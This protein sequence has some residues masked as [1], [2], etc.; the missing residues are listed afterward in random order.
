MNNL[1]YTTSNEKGELPPG[2]RTRFSKSKPDKRVYSKCTTQW[3]R[4]VS[5]KVAEAPTKNS[6]DIRTGGPRSIPR[7]KNLEA[8]EKK[9]IEQTKSE[10]RPTRI[11]NN[12]GA[13]K[14]ELLTKEN[15]PRPVREVAPVPAV[16]ETYK[17]KEEVGDT[18]GSLPPQYQEQCRKNK[19][20][21]GGRKKTRK[22]SRKNKASKG[23]KQTRRR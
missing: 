14:Q 1:K 23:N 7:D 9:T 18:C 17:P 21:K 22:V 19:G 3:E 10:T 13:P 12:G 4:P 20:L 11:S 8:P 15:I 2:W 16:P 6:N 5:M